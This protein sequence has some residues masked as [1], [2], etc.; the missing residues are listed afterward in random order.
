MTTLKTSSE[1]F[2]AN[3]VL[4]VEIAKSLL[5]QRIQTVY[6]GYRGQDGDENFVIGQVVSELE[7]YRNLKEECY[8][9][10]PKFKNRAEYW[11]S[12]MT[13][14]QLSEH[15]NKMVII[16]ADGRNTFIYAHSF[17]DGS[18]TCSDSD[19]FVYYVVVDKAQEL[20]LTRVYHQKG[21]GRVCDFLTNLTLEEV[22]EKNDWLKETD[23][24]IIK[25]RSE[26]VIINDNPKCRETIK[27]NGILSYEY[28]DK[29]PDAYADE[30]AWNE[31]YQ[32]TTG[33]P[34]P[35]GGILR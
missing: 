23:R 30:R 32:K 26:K 10:N 13:E 14:K 7:Y 11:E 18:F 15:R 3:Q 22:I 16:T 28:L 9:N 31:M 27:E 5:G 19:R 12:Y 6:S 17:N 8:Q 24:K 21:D 35:K 4:T 1:I 33:N 25:T 20:E 34:L 29:K 2:A